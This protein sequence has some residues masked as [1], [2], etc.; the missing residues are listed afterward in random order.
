MTDI[1]YRAINIPDDKA[2]EELAYP[3]RRAALLQRI[4]DRGSP[5][6]INQS[7]EAR[8]YGVCHATISN[9]IKKLRAYI[10]EHHDDG[11]TFELWSLRRRVVNGLLDEAEDPDGDAVRALTAA[12]RVQRE[13]QEWLVDRREIEDHAQKI[14]QLEKLADA[15]VLGGD[16]PDPLEDMSDDAREDLLAGPFGGD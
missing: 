1:D 8:R 11:A 13:W 3:A 12:W 16:G 4:E 2:P 5:A 7:A 6:R 14:E 9:D 10:D 15:G